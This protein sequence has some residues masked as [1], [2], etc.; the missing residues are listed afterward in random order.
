MGF[1]LVGDGKGVQADF[2]SAARAHPAGTPSSY[3]GVSDREGR[4]IHLAMRE[5]HELDTCGTA[6]GC[7]MVTAQQ[8][9]PQEWAGLGGIVGRERTEGVV[10][11]RLA[12]R[13][14]AG[15]ALRHWDAVEL[16]ERSAALFVHAVP[17]TSGEGDGEL[18][19]YGSRLQGGAGGETEL[20]DSGEGGARSARSGE[21]PTC[22]RSGLKPTGKRAKGY[23]LRAA[24]QGAHEENRLRRGEECASGQAWEGAAAGKAVSVRVT[25]APELAR[26]PGVGA[27]RE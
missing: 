22:R 6:H 3:A 5:A 27:G 13:R 26:T 14:L 1:R 15:D 8:S 9:D 23:S 24:A 19:R 7:D 12:R 10:T 17:A 18:V 16:A 4:P 2:F 25:G 21:L 20:T 11:D